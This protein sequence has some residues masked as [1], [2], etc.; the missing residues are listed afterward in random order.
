MSQNRWLIIL[1]FPKLVSMK[2]AGDV[3]HCALLSHPSVTLVRTMPNTKQTGSWKKFQCCYFWNI[4]FHC[5]MKLFTKLS[6]VIIFKDCIT[7]FLERRE[8]KEK[9]RRR[10]IMCGC[11]SCAPRWGPGPQPRHVSWPE[12]NWRPFGSHAGTQSTELHQPGRMHS[13]YT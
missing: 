11:L 4:F 1:S 10:N 7:L 5:F 2:D 13:F 8:G 12:Q 3:T 6:I 9:E